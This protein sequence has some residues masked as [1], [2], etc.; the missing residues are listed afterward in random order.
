MAEERLARKRANFAQMAEERQRL[1]EAMAILA[2]SDTEEARSQFA[3]LR[4]RD[5]QLRVLERKF[6]PSLEA[7]EAKLAEFRAKFGA[8]FGAMESAQTAAPVRGAA[9]ERTSRVI[10]QDVKI[11]VAVRD[12]GKCAQCGSAED[13]HYDH[14]IPWSKGGANTVNN[15]Q[16]LCGD[17]NRRKGATELSLSLGLQIS[18]GQ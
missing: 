7:E 17:C 16:L 5:N 10:P 1:Q 15:I 6:R 11:A 2:Q 4:R 9:G 3:D 8:I 12:Q 14:K 18:L 13:I